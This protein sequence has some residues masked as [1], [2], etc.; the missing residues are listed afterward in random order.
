MYPEGFV[1]KKS[2]THIQI[3]TQGTYFVAVYFN[4]YYG[5]DEEN[6]PVYLLVND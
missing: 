1:S 2:N 3:I 6:Q 4:H 5:E